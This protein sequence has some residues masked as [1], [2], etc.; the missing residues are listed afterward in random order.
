ML[1]VGGTRE[2][3]DVELSETESPGRARDQSSDQ[4][5][6]STS[7]STRTVGESLHLLR[8]GMCDHTYT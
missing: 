7:E 3:R 6:I 1:G 4:E 5:N 8:L 2:E